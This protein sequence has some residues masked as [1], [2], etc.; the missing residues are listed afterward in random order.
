MEIRRE[1]IGTTAGH[2]AQPAT[3]VSA[4]TLDTQAG[5]AV[6][7]WTY[8]ATLV[9]VHI[10][11]RAGQLAN[12]T[13]RL[14]DLGSY[15]D[16]RRNPYLGAMLGRFCRCVSGGQFRLGG[17]EY[18][19]DRNDGPHHIHGG[20]L[21]FDR[22]V[23]AAETGRDGDA[24]A[25]RLRLTRPDGDQGY[26]GAV[27][28][29]VTYTAS[30]DMRLILEYWAVTTASTII[31]LTSHAFWNLAGGGSIADHLLAVNAS[32]CLLLDAEFIPLPGAPLDVGGG[33]LDYRISRRIGDDRLDDFFVLDDPAWAAELHEPATGRVM[34]IRTD[35]RGLGIYSG[36][37]L[38]PPRTGLCLQAS[39]WPDA[40]NRA[41]Y[42]SCRLDPGEIYRQRTVHEFAIC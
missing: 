41:D 3:E 12:V 11:D 24:L 2:A 4:Y 35:Q 14:P 10:P 6:T 7:V 38:D 30:P 20:S 19:L 9:E 36:D 5:L 32:R 13:R 37:G 27:T 31:G 29:E 18:V 26:P 1:V 33:R 28:A 17:A 39:A 15:E 22:F 8:G 34:R 42:P 25:V 23:W 21:G 40:P 16:R